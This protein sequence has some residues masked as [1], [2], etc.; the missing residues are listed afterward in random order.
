[1]QWRHFAAV[2]NA[3]I[4]ECSKRPQSTLMNIPRHSAT[5]SPY[6]RASVF[7]LKQYQATRTTNRGSILILNKSYWRNMMHTKSM[8]KTNTR[9]QDMKGKMPSR[10]ARPNTVTSLWRIS[11]P[12]T[13]RTF[14]Q[15][16]KTVTNYEPSPK[17]TTANDTNLP[18]RLDDFYSQFDKLNTT[19]PS[20]ITPTSPLPPF[21]VD[22][23][24]VRSMFQRL[25]SRKAAGPDNTSPCILKLCADQP[26]S[27]FT[28]IFNVKS[29]IASKNQ[30][31]FLFPRNL[32]P[33]V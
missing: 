11:P 25:N 15:G 14:W 22:E 4:E 7:Q 27:V 21:T 32:Q 6:V 24:V 33:L 31:S 18:D 16:L 26:S 28:D 19:F 2:L 13:L 3:L 12:T 5:I 23:Y 1:M 8:T 29:L 30:L 9:K 17:N 10:P 20:S